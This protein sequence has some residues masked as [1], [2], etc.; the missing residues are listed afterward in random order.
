MSGLLGTILSVVAPRILDVVD[1]TVTDKDEAIRL[2][3]ELARILADNEGELA[4]ASASIITTEINGENWLQR[5]WR[6]AL[7]VWFSV[8]VGAYWFG[9]TPPNLSEARTEDL[10]DLVKIG[11]GGYVAGRSIEKTAKIAGSAFTA[12]KGG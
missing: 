5:N 8:L 11:V 2:K 9:W 3:A 6:P 7:M 4:K 12:K 1:Q 10:F